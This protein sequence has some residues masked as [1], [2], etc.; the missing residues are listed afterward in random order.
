MDGFLR[1]GFAASE[2]PLEFNSN[3][4]GFDYSIIL[5]PKRVWN[6]TVKSFADLFVTN[7]K[8][9]SVPYDNIPTGDEISE[10]LLL[11]SVLKF[12]ACLFGMSNVNLILFC[13]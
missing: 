4:S 3:D 13:D 7:S 9:W 10:H 6:H 8:N 12:T 11:I 5:T 1:I 2:G